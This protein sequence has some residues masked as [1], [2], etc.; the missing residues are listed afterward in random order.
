MQQRPSIWWVSISAVRIIY[1]CNYVTKRTSKQL[2]HLE[3]SSKSPLYTVFATTL[4]GIETI[5][6]VL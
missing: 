1:S 4:A 3:A 2:Q 6:Y 5:R